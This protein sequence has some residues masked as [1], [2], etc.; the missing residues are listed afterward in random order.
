MWGYVWDEEYNVHLDSDE[1]ADE[2]LKPKKV[3]T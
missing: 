1:Y 2:Y 3:I